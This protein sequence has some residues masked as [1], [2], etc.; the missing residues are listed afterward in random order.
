M[1]QVTYNNP[2]T[3]EKGINTMKMI[4]QIDRSSNLCFDFDPNLADVL[5]ES[6]LVSLDFDWNGELKKVQVQEF[7]PKI[8]LI[9]ESQIEP[10]KVDTNKQLKEMEQHKQK[11]LAEAAAIEKEMEQL[12]SI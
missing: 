9:K 1:S 6:Q 11:A 2:V 3:M 10:Q 8:I 4:I 5:L 7:K 12:R